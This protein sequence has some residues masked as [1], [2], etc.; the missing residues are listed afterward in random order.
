[1]AKQT[2]QIRLMHAA[3]ME[4]RRS[5]TGS[6]LPEARSPGCSKE[7]V[8]EEGRPMQGRPMIML[9]QERPESDEHR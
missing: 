9:L 6:L 5:P 1:M 3:G 2:M 8:L 7:A 4:H